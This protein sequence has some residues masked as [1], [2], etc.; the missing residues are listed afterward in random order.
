MGRRLQRLVLATCLG[1]FGLGIS[2]AQEEAPWAEQ[3]T[4]EPGDVEVLAGRIVFHWSTI[5]GAKGYRLQVGKTLL[6]NPVTVDQRAERTFVEIPTDA[7]PPR[8]YYWRVSVTGADG[9]DSPFSSARLLNLTPV[10]AATPKP[11]AEKPRRGVIIYKP[12]EPVT[13]QVFTCRSAEGTAM[14]PFRWEGKAWRSRVQVA[15]DEGFTKIVADQTLTKTRHYRVKVPLGTYYSRL[16]Q[17]SAKR[18]WVPVWS[19]VRRFKVELDDEAPLLRVATPASQVF[20]VNAMVT[21]QGATEPGIT[22]TLNGRKL[23]PT[24]RGEFIVDAALKDGRNTLELVAEDD[25]GNETR[26]T[27]VA[28]R[29]PEQ[30]QQTALA[31][32][33]GLQRRLN[34]LDAMREDLDLQAEELTH[35]LLQSDRATPALADNVLAL[36]KELKEHKAFKRALD[37]QVAATA[38]DVE[39]YLAKGR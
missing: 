10:R 16:A 12:T 19:E 15:S 30:L 35:Q 23:S 14:V 34:E 24:D 18:G 4:P 11:V 37:E 21:I 20:T 9:K 28:V 17:Y 32:L 7:L 8:L 33:I 36:E 2:H 25:A 1:I 6:F 26:H 39:A 38:A 3:L 27:V 5:D 29:I 22:L 13:D 31:R